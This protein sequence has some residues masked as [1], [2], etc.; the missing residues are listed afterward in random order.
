MFHAM[1]NRSALSAQQATRYA[2]LGAGH[3]DVARL[4]AGEMPGAG[5]LQIRD[6]HAP[7]G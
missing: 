2:T 1:D 4:L 5:T 6:N 7:R 3:L